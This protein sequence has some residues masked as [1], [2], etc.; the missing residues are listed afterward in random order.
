M[1][2]MSAKKGECQVFPLLL[3]ADFPSQ[4]GTMIFL[5]RKRIKEMI[6]NLQQPAGSLELASDLE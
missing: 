6:K 2:R 1:G 5:P 3:S 4:E